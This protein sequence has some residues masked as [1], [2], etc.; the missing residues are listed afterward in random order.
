MSYIL[1][2]H[3]GIKLEVNIR[4]TTEITQIHRGSVTLLN[5]Q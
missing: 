2:D 3:R 1:R 4:Q 5:D